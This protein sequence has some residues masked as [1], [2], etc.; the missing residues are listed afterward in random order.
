ML[1]SISLATLA[2]AN[3]IPLVG[4]FFWDWDSFSLIYLYWFENVIIGAFFVMRMVIRPYSHPIELAMP[5]FIAPFFFLHY[6]GFTMG[7]GLFIVTLFG[8]DQYNAG[9]S[10]FSGLLAPLWSE[11]NILLATIV[12]FAYHAFDWLM[13]TAKHGLGTDGVKDLMVAPYRRIVI[14]HLSILAGGFAL[15][16]LN[17]PTAG[18]VILIAIK[19]AFDIYHWWQEE[20]Q[21]D[22]ADIDIEAE[23]ERLS[24]EYPE[25]KVTVN[26]QDKVFESFEDMSRSKEWGFMMAI[27]RFMGLTKQI[28]AMRTY[29]A[30]R[31]QQERKQHDHAAR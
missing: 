20:Q 5:L 2:I 6:G 15:Q 31:I 30:L 11:P 19:T 24:A 3:A 18:L 12:L 1:K 9:A 21:E 26:G 10:A 23:L 4:V 16:E 29:M 13:H 8:G 25:P 17:E 27:L 14:L 22:E 7:H 28:K